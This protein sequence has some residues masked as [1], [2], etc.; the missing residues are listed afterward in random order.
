MILSWCG[1]ILLVNPK[2]ISLYAGVLSFLAAHILYIFAFIGL[3]S[4]VNVMVFIFS[5]LLILSS[6]CLF[7]R[8]LNIPNSYKFPIIMYGIAIGLLVVFSLQVFILYRNIASILLVTG[9]ISFFI[10]DMVLVYFTVIKTM[11]K[12]SLIV[13]MLSYIIAQACIVIGFMNI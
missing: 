12:N 11:T 3:V 9:S 7:V 6:E 13:V 8:K 2:K 5:L 10:S 1:D 4:E